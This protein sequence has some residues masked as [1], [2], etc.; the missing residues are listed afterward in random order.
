MT[1]C[2]AARACAG[3][4][5]RTR[6]LRKPSDGEMSEGKLQAARASD[7]K[8]QEARTQKMERATEREPVQ[9]NFTADEGRDTC[10]ISVQEGDSVGRKNWSLERQN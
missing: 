8:A 5:E 10:G 4:D 1:R 9:D 3:E 2:A 6:A 7:S